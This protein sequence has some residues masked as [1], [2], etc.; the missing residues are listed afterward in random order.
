[1]LL[2]FCVLEVVS[3]KW[4]HQVFCGLLV[5][6]G[7]GKPDVEQA[8]HCVCRQLGRAVTHQGPECFR[9]LPDFLQDAQTLQAIR[10]SE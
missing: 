8:V 9:V 1:M 7:P 4:H 10:E 2:T 3:P 5:A 6:P